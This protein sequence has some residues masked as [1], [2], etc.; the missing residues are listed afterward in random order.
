MGARDVLMRVLCVDVLDVEEGLGEDSRLQAAHLTSQNLLH[1]CRALAVLVEELD[2]LPV[3]LQLRDLLERPL[4]DRR[5]H[6]LVD[7]RTQLSYPILYQLWWLAQST[8][9]Q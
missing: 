1:M 3:V 2:I 6:G 5:C 9:R 8:K 4:V 7:L